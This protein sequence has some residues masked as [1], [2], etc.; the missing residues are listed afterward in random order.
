MSVRDCFFGMSEMT[1]HLGYFLENNDLARST[2]TSRTVR[3]GLIPHGCCT[4]DARSPYTVNRHIYNFE[5]I[6]RHTRLVEWLIDKDNLIVATIW[7]NVAAFINLMELI[8]D[9]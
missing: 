3:A 7:S 5:Q 6:I 1:Q 9:M 4:V 2:R 8:L